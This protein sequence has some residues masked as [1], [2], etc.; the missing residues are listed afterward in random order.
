MNAN[1]IIKSF[2][3]MMYTSTRKRAKSKGQSAKIPWLL[4]LS[5]SPSLFRCQ[6]R[7]GRVLTIELSDEGFGDIQRLGGADDTLNFGDIEYQ[8]DAMG[9]GIDI[10]SLADVLIDW[11]QDL[12]ELLIKG[13]LSIF[14]FTLIVFLHL[15]DLIILL[16]RDLGILER[17]SFIQIG[18]RLLNLLLQGLQL[19]PPR[20][21]L[22]IDFLDSRHKAINTL[23]L[24]SELGT[25]N[26][27][28]LGVGY[29]AG[30][31]W[32]R[33]GRRRIGARLSEGGPGTGRREKSE[34][35][36]PTK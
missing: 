20:L 9:L 23:L 36:Y 25:I 34:R 6:C 24:I 26:E 15:L 2:L 19:S 3:F 27:R 5:V 16:R 35:G 8:R 7:S 4:A 14:A 31:G 21:K 12:L 11:A 29:T 17:C 32:S 28:D 30:L 1:A 10:E 22:G 18:S 33:R 13:S